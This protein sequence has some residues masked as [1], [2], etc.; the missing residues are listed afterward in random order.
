MIIKLSGKTS[1]LNFHFERHFS[2]DEHKIALLGFYGLNTINNITNKNN[3]IY[4]GEN[5]LEIP[6]GQYNYLSLK[7]YLQS[8]GFDLIKNN[9]KIE[10]HHHSTPSQST[11]SEIYISDKREDSLTEML[12]SSK[13]FIPV[14][15]INIY[16]NLCEG[17]LVE[18]G[19]FVHKETNII[20][21]FK[22]NSSFNHPII[23]EPKT[24]I[25]FPVHINN[26][27]NIELRICDENGELIDFNGSDITV[28]LKL[29]AAS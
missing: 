17:M 4:Y 14:E 2:N 24:P 3:K 19:E 12:N 7:H 16:C 20:S 22:M 11:W 27:Y 1:I 8:K 9:N 6:P 23:F 26:I 13:K 21:S 5:V 10:I 25:Y 28:V 29:D 18:G 15:I